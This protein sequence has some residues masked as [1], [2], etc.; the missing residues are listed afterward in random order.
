MSY[1]ALLRSKVRKAFS[2]VGDIKAIVTLSQKASASFD[3]STGLATTG[4]STV[5]T[6]ECIVVARKKEATRSRGAQTQQL[7]MDS[8]MQLLFKA[9]DIDDVTVYDT[10]TMPDGKVWSLILPFETDGY[11]VTATV[12][13]GV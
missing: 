7:S 2:A 13:K 8:Q 5:K 4:S 1:D 6:V 12:S 3:F 10:V 11:L 9:D